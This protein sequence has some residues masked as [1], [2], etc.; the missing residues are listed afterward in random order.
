MST[1]GLGFLDKEE[2]KIVGKCEEQKIKWNPRPGCSV[3]WKHLSFNTVQ[4]QKP[5]QIQKSGGG[6]CLSPNM[7]NQKKTQLSFSPS[8]PNRFD[9]KGTEVFLYPLTKDHFLVQKEKK[10]SL[11][12]N[13][14]ET[15]F[16]LR[17]GA[18]QVYIADQREVI[19]GL[20]PF[21]TMELEPVKKLAFVQTFYLARFCFCQNPRSP[22]FAKQIT[23]IWKKSVVKK[24]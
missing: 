24:K 4:I 21:T 5:V 13:A 6:L 22:L 15:I 8:S 7:W 3:L 1:L 9:K 19:Q 18:N 11:M 2:F 12:A 20:F 14:L 10:I 16:Y 17:E 23:K